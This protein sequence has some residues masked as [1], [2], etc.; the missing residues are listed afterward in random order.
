MVRNYSHRASTDLSVSRSNLNM[1]E[2]VFMS[3]L[4]F[5]KFDATPLQRDP[6]DYILVPEFVRPEALGAINADF[7]Q[8]TDPGN[9]PVDDIT[10]GP[11][12]RDLVDELTGAEMRRHFA[13]KFEMDLDP[14][15]TQMTVRR[16]M[17]SYDGNIHN[18][19]KTKK[20]TV[21]IYFN[22]EWHQKGGQ[23]RLT[24]SLHDMDDYYLEIPPVKG[25][26]F[27]FK[28]NERSFHGF[29]PGEGERR[30]IQMYWVDPKRK[31]K[32]KATG[33]PQLVRKTLLRTFRLG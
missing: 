22:E 6:C 20:I 3:V 29:P 25:T 21:L 11:H 4:D 15:P 5:A 33:F 30:T 1:F 7:P 17:A 12:F 28:R 31:L 8:I 10:Y 26:L 19:A 24:R 18:D 32:K 27:A 14:L 2:G 23:L 9:Y 13:A 16:Y